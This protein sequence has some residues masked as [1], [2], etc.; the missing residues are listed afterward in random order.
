MGLAPLNLR[1]RVEAGEIF[2][3]LKQFN[4]AAEQFRMATRLNPGLGQNWFLYGSA[5][6]T[7]G[8]PT[9]AVDS[10][11]TAVQLLPEFVPARLNLAAS[12]MKSGRANEALDQLEEVLQRDPTN[13]LA[14]MYAAA[15]RS[16][17][18]ATNSNRLP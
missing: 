12:L 9:Q 4:A 2:A 1:V 6:L 14:R 16:R 7:S 17:E 10:L 18:T 8:Q 13:S 3:A 5:L 15:L 11:Q